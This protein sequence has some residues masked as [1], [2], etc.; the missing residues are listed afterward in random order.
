MYR[1][2]NDEEHLYT[3]DELV[4]LGMPSNSE[5]NFDIDRRS[6]ITAAGA[7][8]ITGLAGCTGGNGGN[9]N[10]GGANAGD[11]NGE[12]T[13][14]EYWT[15]FGGGD[16]KAMEKM[17]NTFN[18]NHDKITINRQRLPWDQYYDKLY[19]ALT[20]GNAPDLAVV[21]A[22]QLAVYKDVLQP[23]GDLV[24]DETA[25]GYVDSIWQQVKLD[26]K[27]LSL[28]LDTH[29]I[30]FYYNKSIFEEAGLDPEK[31]PE[32]P[33]A[34]T[35][36]CNTIVNET[37]KLAFSP[38]PYGPGELL[39]VY[40]AFLRQSGGQLLNDDKTKAAFDTETGIAVAEY[41][42]NMTGKWGWDRP[43]MADNRWEKA[44]YAG[45]LAMLA[46]G[47]WFYG[48][49]ADQDFEFGMFKP[50]VYPGGDQQYTWADS[51][52]LALPMNP[53]RSDAKQQAAL[54]AARWLTQETNTWG[55]DAGHLP[56]SQSILKSDT[57]QQSDVWDK[58]LSTFSEMADNDALAY[59]PR[60]STIDTYQE[61]ISENLA[62]IYSQ[63]VSP[64]EGIRQAA[65]GVNKALQQ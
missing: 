39:R 15:L 59:V 16:G 19:T 11:S 13:T 32:S 31:P 54:E 50:F 8:G 48:P 61:R 33:K 1:Q 5:T 43:E 3:H 22:S 65:Q 38:T 36:A 58:T 56:A 34:F 51:H 18:E 45:D 41:F 47:T 25:N 44:F 23:L 62:Q 64:E 40:L 27:R 21:H 14:I 20:G 49:A 63:Q 29:P 57:L 12:K 9:G 60:T 7:A 17:V 10:S 30:G 2:L 28:P 55:T 53:K 52:T 46:N 24:N 37:D 4:S 42:S 35:E 26:G 6:F